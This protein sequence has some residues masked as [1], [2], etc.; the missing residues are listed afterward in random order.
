[1][2]KVNLYKLKRVNN[3][4]AAN[5]NDFYYFFLFLQVEIDLNKHQQINVLTNIHYITNSI[6][7]S[8]T[9]YLNPFTSSI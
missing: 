9:S 6:V 1:M 8:P 2:F 3:D 7:P 5:K 4:Q